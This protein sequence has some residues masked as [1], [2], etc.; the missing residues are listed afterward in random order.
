V[1]SPYPLPSTEAVQQI[2]WDIAG[3]LNVDQ[4]LALAVAKQ[5]SQFLANL[6]SSAGAYGVMQLMPKTAKEYGVKDDFNV[7]QNVTAGLTF[8]GKLSRRYR[9]NLVA[10]LASYNWGGGNP[11]EPRTLAWLKKNPAVLAIDTE[12]KVFLRND[13]ILQGLPLQTRT[14]IEIISKQLRSFSD[15]SAR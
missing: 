13:P 14:Y 1:Q 7:Q 10:V 11:R 2:V 5:E 12:N 8:L 4:Y 3:K 15:A 9:D 6:R